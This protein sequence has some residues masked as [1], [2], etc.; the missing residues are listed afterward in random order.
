MMLRQRLERLL[1]VGRAA[2][3]MPPFDRRFA[4]V[5]LVLAGLGAI[6]A[7]L[8]GVEVSQT[9]TEPLDETAARIKL[10]PVEVTAE[11]EGFVEKLV[12]T[13]DAWVGE[14]VTVRLVDDGDGSVVKVQA[15]SAAL[16]TIRMKW[17]ADVPAGARLYTEKTRGEW[18]A[19]DEWADSLWFFLLDRGDR[20]EG[21][22]VRTQPNAF[23]SW[24]VSPGA[25]EAV[26]DVRAGG[27]GVKLGPRVLDAAVL[28]RR[29]GIPGESA[30]AAGRAFCRMMCPTPRLPKEPVYGYNDWY[31]AYGANTATNFLADAAYVTEMAKGLRTRP[32][33]VMDDG[34]QPN[35][36]PEIKRKTGIFDSGCGPWEKAG[37]AFGMD[38]KTFAGKIAALGAKPGLWYRPMRTWEEV[39]DEQRLEN[40]KRFFD[41]TV[42]AV[43]ERIAAD[44]ARFRDWGFRL[45]KADYITYDFCGQYMHNVK[46]VSHIVPDSVRWRDESRTTAEVM[47]DVYQTIHEAAGDAM[48][49]IGCNAVNHFAAGLFEIQRTGRDTSGWS[50]QKTAECGVNALGMRNMMNGTFYAADPDCVGLAQEGAVPWEKNR[51]WLELVARSKSPLFIS[52]R[53]SLATPDV[54]AAFRAAFDTLCRPGRVGEPLDWQTEALPRRWRFDDGERTYDWFSSGSLGAFENGRRELF[55]GKDLSNW[56]THVRR[57]GR[58]YDPCGVFE[59]KEGSILCSGKEQGWLGSC[60]TFG[61]VR[62]EVE[63][64]EGGDS[65]DWNL[66]TLVRKNGVVKRTFARPPAG[67]IVRVSPDNGRIFLLSEGRPVKFRRVTIFN[68]SGL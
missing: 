31:C 48:V 3:M 45:V 59:V 62:L 64:R 22:G 9:A 20:T 50:W 10:A 40:D 25:V 6:S 4:I 46:D 41:P 56:Y 21:W 53:R 7:A 67:E 1:R 38:M 19:L 39:P 42:P 68:G 63:F 47:R 37:D 55:G 32:Y 43:K 16:R 18:A 34:W 2:S 23:V 29:E 36:P 14:R 26:F 66:A 11:G 15:P 57:R 12:R 30:F 60:E 61:D 17:T 35:S 28:L 65:G 8:A 58:E 5:S 54:R 33:V 44:V 49:V 27:R 52:W 13:G 51:E 24:R